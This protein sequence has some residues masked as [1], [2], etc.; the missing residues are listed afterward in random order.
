MLLAFLHPVLFGNRPKSPPSTHSRP[1]HVLRHPQA[2]PSS[3]SHS[4]SLERKKL[5]KN[6]TQCHDFQEFLGVVRCF[7]GFTWFYFVL[8]FFRPPRALSCNP[9]AQ[10]DQP[11]WFDGVVF[12]WIRVGVS[13]FLRHNQTT[14]IFLENMFCSLAPRQSLLHTSEFTKAFHGTDSRLGYPNNLEVKDHANASKWYLLMDVEEQTTL[15]PK[16]S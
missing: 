3:N 2:L 5:Q 6:F 11:K 4:C 7:F 16:N 9:P 12:H 1:P 15:I 10:R 13:C 8:H 14:I